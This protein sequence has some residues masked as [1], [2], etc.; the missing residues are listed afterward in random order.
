VAPVIPPGYDNWLLDFE[1]V[2]DEGMTKLIEFWQ[3]KD[4][5]PV[6]MAGH[7]AKRRFLEATDPAKGQAIR[8]KAEAA[9]TKKPV[10][11]K[12]VTR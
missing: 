2:A 3:G 8:K 1:A 9:D 11:A 10:T 5:D 12:A 4:L 7:Q 6:A